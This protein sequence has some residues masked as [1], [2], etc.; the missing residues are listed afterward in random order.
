MIHNSNEII[1]GLQHFQDRVER[2]T[3]SHQIYELELMYISEAINLINSYEKEIER[4]QSCV[5]S[6][7][8]VR[9]IMKSCMGDVVKDTVNEQIDNAHRIGQVYAIQEFERRTLSEFSGS[10]IMN[11]YHVINRIN[12]IVKDMLVALG[13]PEKIPY[14]QEYEDDCCDICSGSGMVG[15]EYCPKCRGTGNITIQKGYNPEEFK[16]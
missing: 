8:E 16:K 2:S 12:D 15:N 9:R 3:L 6:E 4:L 7:D 14:A 10:N 1:Q 13:C 11:G 5:K